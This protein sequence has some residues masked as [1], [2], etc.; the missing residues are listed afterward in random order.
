MSDFFVKIRPGENGAQL[1]KH[2][3]LFLVKNEKRDLIL[4]EKLLFLQGGFSFQN[5]SGNM[6]NIVTRTFGVDFIYFDIFFLVC[7]IVFL[8]YKKYYTA[9]RWGLAGWIIYIF[10]DYLLWFRIMGSRHYS[11]PIDTELFFAWFCFSPGFVQFSYV[12]VMFEKRSVREAVF[13]TL[14]FYCGWTAVGLLSQWI[15]LDDTL[16]RAARDMGKGNQRLIMGGLALANFIIGIIMVFYHKIK[17]KDLLYLF[18]VGTLVEFAL[19]F[20]LLVSGIRLEQG[21]WSMG[22]M[23]V[24]SLIEF[25]CG[26]IMM[27]IIWR[28]L[29]GKKW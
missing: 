3:V 4:Y 14:F 13:W 7:W 9:I 15:P 27:Y 16:L 22:M 1:N 29:F 12:I 20:S 11:G 25:N 17:W 8:V 10:I 18:L 28:F 21:Q 6:N 26:I 23:L 19:E 5:T 24:N 2:I